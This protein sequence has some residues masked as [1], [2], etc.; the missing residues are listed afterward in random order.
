MGYLVAVCRRA[1][2]A[3]LLLAMAGGA[4]ASE[5]ETI[6]GWVETAR[7]SPGR[8]QII[9][10]LDTGSLSSSI[11]AHDITEFDRDGERW[12]R[13]TVVNRA[14]RAR[15]L[16]LPVVRD[17]VIK[18]HG[19]EKNER[20]VVMMGICIGD[21]YAETQVSLVDRSG[22]LYP[23][24]IGRRYLKGTFLVDASRKYTVKPRCGKKE[25]AGE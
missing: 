13:F 3:A 25:T 20:P 9:A 24:L 21:H 10:K 19:G 22:F 5:P 12:V 17:V 11:N 7:I 23:L 1:A 6:V 4:P 18:D 14:G 16:E 8:M 15:T 2:P